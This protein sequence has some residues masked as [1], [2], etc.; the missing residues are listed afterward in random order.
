MNSE[1]S[2]R[3]S[4]SLLLINVSKKKWSSANVSSLL[5]VSQ[6]TNWDLF[7]ESC[8]VV[9]FEVKNN[10]D[11]DDSDDFENQYTFAFMLSLRCCRRPAA[12]PPAR[13]PGW[14]RRPCS[15]QTPPTAAWVCGKEIWGEMTETGT[16]TECR[17]DV[18][19]SVVHTVPFHIF[20]DQI[21]LLKI[22]IVD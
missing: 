5:F 13:C 7:G 16:T 10:H 17:E 6:E 1:C 18:E 14:S 19:P 11:L 2:S 21:Q 9:T 15:T 4:I 3:V 20:Y 12:P 8:S 22:F